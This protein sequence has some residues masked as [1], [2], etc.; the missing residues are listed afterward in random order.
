TGLILLVSDARYHLQHWRTAMRAFILLVLL[1]APLARFW[2]SMPDEYFNRLDMYGSFWASD[3]STIA[4]VGNY[5]RIYVS[6]L[7]P[8]YWFFTHSYDTPIHT[9]PGYGHIHWLM[10]P[11]FLTGL[12]QAFRGWKMPE[13]RVL[14]AALLAAPAGTA[15]AEL[16]VNR[17]LTIIIP[18]LLLGLVG[19]VAMQ[20]WLQQ[21]RPVLS[22]VFTAGIPAVLALFSVFM[23]VDALTN[24]PTWYTSYGLS[25]MQWGARQ[26]YAGAHTYIR[27]HPDHTLYISPNWTFQ[28]EVIREFFAPGEQRIRVGAIDGII[29]SFD[30]ALSQ[31]SFVLMPEE[32]E[33]IKGSRRFHEPQIDQII[34]YPDGRPGFY[35]V[36]LAYLD[37]I[38]EIIRSEQEERRRIHETEVVI[39]GQRV[40]L[41]HTALEGDINSLFDGSPDTLVKTQGINPMMV[42]LEFSDAVELYGV[43]ARVGAEPVE[44]IVEIQGD[45]VDRK[46][47]VQAGELAPYKNV[48]VDFAGGERVVKL[49]FTLRD[50]HAPE[51]SFVHLWELT[52][53]FVR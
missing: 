4:K 44:I 50:T 6:G 20:G 37:D 38:E 15:M 30:P 11:P 12:W 46:F 27:Q 33:R 39:N 16:H 7:N 42:E 21:R 23:T 31:K 48:P 10:L 51:T 32:Y 24:G 35:F 19:I 28:A 8:L 49:R 14:L 36:R 34:P 52:L 41:R 26:V 13:M 2:L 1:A 3:I 43:I 53:D 22:Q 40:I 18:V 9:M 45:E 29:S 25:G 17:V 47:V 5:I